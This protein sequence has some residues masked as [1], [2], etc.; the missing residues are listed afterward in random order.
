MPT[1]ID[2]ETWLS[3]GKAARLL[4]VSR[5]TLTRWGNEGLLVAHQPGGKGHH[6]K[7]L[8]DSVAAMLYP[9]ADPSDED[10]SYDTI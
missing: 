4:G 6:R 8:T 5:Q 1:S 7:Y 3:P 10:T 9:E 2:G